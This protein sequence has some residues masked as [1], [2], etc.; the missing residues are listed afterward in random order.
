MKN[1]SD[2][3]DGTRIGQVLDM[4]GR[5]QDWLAAKIGVSPAAVN[6]WIRGQRKIDVETAR[7]VASA[8]DTPFFMLF[9]IPKVVETTTCDVSVEGTAA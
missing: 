5:R 8:L 1:F 6:R 7:K 9:D 4:Q 3:L 2:R